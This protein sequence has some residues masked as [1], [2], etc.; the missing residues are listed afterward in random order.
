MIDR[1]RNSKINNIHNNSLNQNDKQTVSPNFKGRF[2][3]KTVDY[4]V[5]GIRACEKNPMI[6]VAVIDLVTAIGPRSIWESFTNLF[7]GFEAFRRESSGLLVNCLIPGFIALAAA[8]AVNNMIMGDKA[9]LSSCWAGK[10]TIDTISDYYKNA[11][12]TEAYKDGMVKFNDSKKARVYATH[13]NMLSDAQGVDGNFTKNFK[14]IEE[15]NIS[16]TAEKLTE[17]TFEEQKKLSFG[18]K[19]KAM[20]RSLKGIFNKSKAPKEKSLIDKAFETASS[21]THITENVKFGKT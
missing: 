16:E 12:E 7:A 6:N 4:A 15:F 2:V 18:E 21:Q 17:A 10:D 14:D 9:D 8:K 11:E 19:I 13:Y 1:I 3:D 20:G 5:R